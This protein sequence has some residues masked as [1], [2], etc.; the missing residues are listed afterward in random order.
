MRVVA[1]LPLIG[2]PAIRPNLGW[3]QNLPAGPQDNAHRL[4]VEH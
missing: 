4:V 1:I 3:P 2:E